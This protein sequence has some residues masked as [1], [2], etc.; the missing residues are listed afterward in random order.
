MIAHRLT[1]VQEC[2]VIYMLEKGE[3]TAKGT[4]SELIE[5]SS[6]FRKM[7]NVAHPGPAI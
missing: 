2:D 1:T 7:A 4:Y 6:Q 5:S 3:V